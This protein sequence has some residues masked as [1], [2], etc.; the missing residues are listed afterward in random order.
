MARAAVLA[1]ALV[2]VGTAFGYG[3]RAGTGTVACSARSF[4]VSFDPARH[5]VVESGGTVLASATFGARSLGATC[6]GVADPEGFDKGG[7]G[8][9]IRSATAFHCAASAPIRIHANAIRSATGKIVGSTVSV[10]IGAPRLTVIVSA[11]LKNRGDPNAS[12]VY[13]ARSYCKLGARS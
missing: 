4:D 1:L 2:A 3:A 8:P 11:V 13:R 9:E 7:L 6:R 5:V 10:G 12:R